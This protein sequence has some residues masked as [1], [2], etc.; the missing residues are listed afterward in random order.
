ML[1]EKPHKKQINKISLKR[2]GVCPM[3]E[4]ISG[5]PYKKGLL[6]RILG[7]VVIKRFATDGCACM[8]HPYL[9]YGGKFKKALYNLGIVVAG[10]TLSSK[11]ALPAGILYFALLVRL[12]VLV[13]ITCHVI[14]GM[15]SGN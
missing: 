9:T 2:P 4:Q 3:K 1:T 14:M 13:I 12:A 6:F 10:I 8:V 11:I 5:L 7:M 15:V